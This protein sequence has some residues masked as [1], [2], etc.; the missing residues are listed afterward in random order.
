MWYNR[1]NRFGGAGNEGKGLLPRNLDFGELAA[2]IGTRLRSIVVFR[3][4][5]MH[6]D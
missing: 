2:A 6:P 3:L 1:P 5:V 4:R